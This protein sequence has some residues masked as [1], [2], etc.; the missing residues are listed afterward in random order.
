MLGKTLFLGFMS[1]TL[2]CVALLNTFPKPTEIPLLWLLSTST[3]LVV[4]NTH[5][6]MCG[7]LMKSPL[8][9]W[10]L[11]YLS[12]RELQCKITLCGTAQ[13][14]ENEEGDRCLPSGN[15]NLT[16]AVMVFCYG[17]G[18]CWP[19]CLLDGRYPDCPLALP[20]PPRPLPPAPP[21]GS[22]AEEALC[23]H[24]SHPSA[25]RPFRKYSFFHLLA[26]NLLC[27]YS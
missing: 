24:P 5:L 20:S 27:D 6:R 26:Y 1:K 22:W 25:P 18:G 16:N 9:F 12:C 21:W 3:E 17:N 15:D 23:S 19:E 4:W 11:S 13:S 10:K 2:S 14:R 8:V 7:S